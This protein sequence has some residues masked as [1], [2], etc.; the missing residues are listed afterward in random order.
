MMKVFNPLFLIGQ[1][2]T[3]KKR[4][5]SPEGDHLTSINVYRASNDFMEM[6]KLLVGNKKHENILR[7]WCRENFINS[8]S[9][10]PARDIHRYAVP[11]QICNEYT[12]SICILSGSGICNFPLF[13]AEKIN[14]PD[15][16]DIYSAGLILIQVGDPLKVKVNKLTSIKTQL[17]I[18]E[19]LPP[20]VTNK[21]VRSGVSTVYQRGYHI[22]LKGQYS[23]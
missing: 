20:I 5:T 7:K 23:G 13:C 2:R 15:R 4:F 21:K 1:S 16:F 6:R 8:R 10:R 11:E 14:L 3:A 22:G 18:L 12:N 17:P 9:L 19:N